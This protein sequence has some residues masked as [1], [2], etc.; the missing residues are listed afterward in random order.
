[1][2][3]SI[4]FILE[5]P[6][7][8][9]DLTSVSPHLIDVIQAENRIELLKLSIY[10]AVYGHKKRVLNNYHKTNK[11]DD[12]RNKLLIRAI[13]ENYPNL[14]QSFITWIEETKKL[15]E[16]RNTACHGFLVIR[17]H[18]NNKI[19]L[20]EHKEFA[21]YFE[22]KIFD[23]SAPLLTDTKIENLPFTIID[24]EKIH[25]FD[26]MFK[27]LVLWAKTF[28]RYIYSSDPAE[29]GAL[30][31]ILKEKTIQTLLN[32]QKPTTLA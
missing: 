11:K 9:G 13:T 16:Y 8:S 10:S 3:R 6:S 26:S 5:M 4:E 1:M 31:F 27:K 32:N 23:N 28:L 2:S 15:T 17:P 25:E 14:T 30:L 21:D 19:A 22:N 29:K 7:G 18:E 12:G 20:Y 24:S